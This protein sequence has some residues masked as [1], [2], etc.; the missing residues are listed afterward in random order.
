MTS[1]CWPHTR[2]GRCTARSVLRVLFATTN[3]SVLFVLPIA[4]DNNILV[5]VYPPPGRCNICLS[6]AKKTVYNYPIALVFVRRAGYKISAL[7]LPPRPSPPQLPPSQPLAGSSRWDASRALL[8]GGAFYMC[9]YAIH[10]CLHNMH[11][12]I[13]QHHHPQIKHSA[14]LLFKNYNEQH[15]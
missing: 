8:T 1:S 7:S 5:L 12:S 13:R 10:P 15:R 9:S 11:Q 6:R 14:C 4:S 3:C 2:Q